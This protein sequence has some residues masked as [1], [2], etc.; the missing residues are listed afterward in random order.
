MRV[1]AFMN[2]D[3]YALN[4]AVGEPLDDDTHT[5]PVELDFCSIKYCN[6]WKGVLGCLLSF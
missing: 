5:F 3:R 4:L 1:F 2:M 6:S